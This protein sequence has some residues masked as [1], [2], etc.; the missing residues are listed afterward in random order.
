MFSSS[1]TC[2]E[3]GSGEL[4]SGLVVVI[5][6][7]NRDPERATIA[8]V[9]AHQVDVERDDP[10]YRRLPQHGN[11]SIRIW[12]RDCRESSWLTILESP[13]QLLLQQRK[14]REDG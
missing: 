2:P 14:Q 4:E 3:C 13:G 9:T 10:Q 7:D 11:I 8:R 5:R 1:L 12:C 6:P